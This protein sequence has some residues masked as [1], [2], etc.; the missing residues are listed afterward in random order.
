MGRSWQEVNTLLVEADR[1][2]NCEEPIRYEGPFHVGVDLG[3][4]DVVLMVVDDHAR[5]LAAFLEWA[6]VVRDGVVV[7]FVGAVDIVRRLVA[8]AQ[9]RL[10]VEITQASTSFPPGTDPRLSTNI[11]ETAGLDVVQVVDEPSCVGALLDLDRAAVVDIGGGTTG[12]AILGRGEVVFSDDE[13]TGGTHITLV[14]AGRTGLSF[15]EA[16]EKKRSPDDWNILDMARPTLQRICDIVGG[17]IGGH[18]V[19]EIILSGGTCC[20]EGIEAVFTSELGLPVK[21]PS[22]PLLLTPLA[23]ASLPMN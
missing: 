16:E 15:Q 17:H 12:T 14:I 11:L 13:P 19:E 5:P 20:L 21:V 7:D 2:L 4:A 6:Q 10:G 18:D 9:A 23:I 1:I 8:K 3:T 22:R